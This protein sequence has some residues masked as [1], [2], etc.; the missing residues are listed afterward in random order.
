MVAAVQPSEQVCE[1]VDLTARRAALSVGGVSVELR[2]VTRV[3]VVEYFPLVRRAVAQTLAADERLA[4]VGVAESASH[5]VRLAEDARAHIVVT[6]VHL[7]AQNEGLGLCRKIKHLT[8]QPR[9]VVYTAE[10]SAQIIADCVAA[11]ADSFVHK[12]VEPEELVEAVWATRLD[13]RSWLLGDEAADDVRPEALPVRYLTDREQQVL[14]LLVR[15]LT[16][17]EICAELHLA[18]QTVKN[19]VSSVLRKVGFR[20]RRELVTLPGAARGSQW[21]AA[22]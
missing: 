8:H 15:R 9:G 7:R 10:R 22:R 4:V 1:A 16:N 13:R 21:I 5:G 11:R 3:V 18:P 6:E 17:E 12:S 20:S 2:G 14:A 19:H